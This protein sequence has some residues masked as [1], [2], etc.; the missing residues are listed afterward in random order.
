[1]YRKCDFCNANLDP[2]EVCDCEIDRKLEL[3]IKIFIKER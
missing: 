2:N 3:E 1:M